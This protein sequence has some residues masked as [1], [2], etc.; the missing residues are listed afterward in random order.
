MS[1]INALARPCNGHYLQ[2]NGE[3][4][5]L[6]DSQ[7]VERALRM[8]ACGQERGTAHDASLGPAPGR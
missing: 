1:E 4:A 8:L 7:E 2:V 6:L 3:V 5:E